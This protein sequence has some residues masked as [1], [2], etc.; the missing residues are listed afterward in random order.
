M[1]NKT[2]TKIV[3]ENLN[4]GKLKDMESNAAKFASIINNRKESNES[5]EAGV[6]ARTYGGINTTRAL[7]LT[8]GSC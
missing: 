2:K 3:N 6:G 1:I 5:S 8:T 4:R 7:C